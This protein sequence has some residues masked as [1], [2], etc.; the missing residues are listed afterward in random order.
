MQ[1]GRAV[2]RPDLDADEVAHWQSGGG[3][4]SV[5]SLTIDLCDLKPIPNDNALQSFVGSSAT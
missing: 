1:A 3:G 4:R 2:L 5:V